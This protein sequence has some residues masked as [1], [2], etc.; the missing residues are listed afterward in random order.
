MKIDLHTHI[1]PERWEDFAA[2]YGGGRWPRLVHHD[3]C[4]ATIMTGEQFFRDVDDRSFRPERRI[5]DMDRLGIDRQ[6]LSPPPVMFC[7][8]ADAKANAAFARMQNENVA[9][10]AARHPDRFT[11][12]ATVPLQDPALAVEELTHC[13]ERLGLRAVEIGTCP[14]G[15]D[16]DDPALFPFFRACRDLGVA[17]F[18]HPASPL[19][20]QER[21][22]KYYFPLIVGNP[23]E[24]ALA[25]SKLIYGAVLERLPDLRICFAHGGG[26]FAFTLGRLNHGW[27][28]RPEGRQAIP[29]EPREYAR[30]IYVDSLTHSPANTRFLVEQL[31]RDRVVLGSDYPFDMGSPDPVAALAEAGLDAA[32]R[33]AIEGT[34]AAR[35]LGL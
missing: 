23:L 27:S 2:R 6:A 7:Y 17:V 21:L 20:G 33:A 14:G 13:R 24:S 31:G 16:F 9:A 8:W 19:V 25:I 28:V 18:V 29:R 4:R 10:I 34:N 30:L 12:M 15:R 32:T 1:V 35:F 11:A 26:A 22:T 3:A 5:E